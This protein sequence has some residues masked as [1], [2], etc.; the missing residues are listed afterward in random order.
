MTT[1]RSATEAP[2]ASPAPPPEREIPRRA[3][4]TNLLNPKT[5]L[6]FAAF[7]PRF[8]SRDR[9]PLW[10]QLLT[11]GLVF[12]AVGLLWDSM[13]GLCAGHDIPGDPAPARGPAA[14]MCAAATTLHRTRSS[15]C[16][17]VGEGPAP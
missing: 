15:D 9:G 7:L 4:V 5:I 16:R 14:K 12:L 13:L 10:L 17:G 8:T 11:L 1:L 3:A 2:A 6:F